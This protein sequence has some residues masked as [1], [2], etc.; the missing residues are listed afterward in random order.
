MMSED[1]ELPETY[2]SENGSGSRDGGAENCS[3]G[4]F[5]T[6]GGDVSSEQNRL[7][8]LNADVSLALV[9]SNSLKDIL[10]L[11]AEA[12]VRHLDAAF[13]RIWTFNEA[14]NILELQA[15]AG[16]YTHTDGA[17]AS[18]PVGQFKIGLIA[19]ERKPH[20]TNQVVGDERVANQEWA[21][22]ERMVS[23][24]GY[25]LVVEQKLVGV[26]G[27][28]SRRALD[29]TIIGALASVA[30]IVALGIERKRAEEVLRKS[31]ERYRAVVEVSPQ[32]VWTANADGYITFF[33][34]HW[35]EYTGMTLAE[36]QGEGWTKAIRPDYR[37]K[38]AESRLNSVEAGSWE[39]E[40]PLRRA[41][42][43]EYRWHLARGL[44]IR[45]D[46]G[47][48]ARWLGVAIDIHERQAVAFERERLLEA[49]R[50]AREESETLRNIGQIISG[51]LD[52]QKIVQAVTDAATELTGAQFGAFFYNVLDADGASYMLYTLS[53]EKKEAFA[54]FPMPRA[55]EMFGPTFR[56]EGTIRIGDARADARYAKNPPYKG[57]PA[58]HPIVAS[59]LA[60]SVFS[61]AGEVIGGLFFGHE[62]ANI[63]SVRDERI[64]EAL[65][66]QASVAMENAQLLEATKKER[67]KAEVAALENELLL[68]QA[69]EANRLKD[70]FL[71][72]VSHELRT[73]L[74]AITGWSSLLLSGK[75][76]SE[77]ARRSAIETINRNAR[78]QAQIIEDILDVSRIISGK[79]RLDV[80]LI[81][82]AS[83]IETA[84]ESARPAA[85]AK[86]IRLQT[87]LDP[88]AAP[89]SGDPDRL[90]QVCWNLISNAVKF[91]PKGGRIQVRL[92]RVNSHVEISVSDT[93]QGIAE[94]FLPHVFEHFRQ[95]DSSTSRTSGGLGLGLSIARR[96]VEMHGGSV[97]VASPGEGKGS[98]FVVTLPISIVHRENFEDKDEPR[99][100][101]KADERGAVGFDCPPELK[102]LR[103]LVVDD[104]PDAREL[105]TTVLKQCQ[106]QVLTVA[107]AS[108]ALEKIGEFDP[109]ILVSDIGLPEVDGYDLIRKVRANERKTNAKRIPAVALTAYARVDD[110]M[111]ALA[112]GF[113]MHVPKPVEPAELAA[114]IASL[115]DWESNQY[116]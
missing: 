114:V 63:F 5:E 12:V 100:H 76:E 37:E 31:E 84:V 107:S 71:A 60:I 22:R 25:P 44:A 68:A 55:T 35:L 24:A 62:K 59:Y 29:E 8:Q 88:H 16:I 112:A 28:F 115:T 56:G 27:M 102:G 52:L 51:E 104:E 72:V 21:K 49:E 90:Q 80:R 2:S 79:L 93:G 82:P 91:T 69:Q 108:E 15:S 70:D 32:I 116:D 101:P 19:A 53:G 39:I 41:A 113:Q 78:A 10:H 109:H 43:G 40:I 64:V 61:R 50:E 20:L 4:Q 110:R 77:T 45:N 66:A 81:N 83:I 6:I 54:G 92:E 111:K 58:G 42:D 3:P 36:S 34:R 87:L 14:E 38:V 13:A 89:V 47:E 17:H 86:D 57:L 1:R 94:D 67:A 74:N 48:I 73:P 106:A 105:L 7:A 9:E 98:T 85:D 96:I 75:M 30:N 33:N 23:F 26:I 103:V 99:V 65:A 95:K 11:C 46:A 97:S 18:V